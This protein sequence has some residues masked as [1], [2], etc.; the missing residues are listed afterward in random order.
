MQ[1]LIVEPMKPPYVTN[2]GNMSRKWSR[3][4]LLTIIGIIAMTLLEA[5]NT[6]SSLNLD[7]CALVVGLVFFFIVEAISETSRAKLGLRLKTVPADLEKPGVLFVLLLPVVSAIVSYFLGKLLLG[8]RIVEHVLARISPMLSFGKI[9]LLIG[10]LIIGALIEEIAFRGFFVGKGMKLFPCW[11]CVLISSAVFAA[12]H[13]Y[14]GDPA[15]VAFDLLFV[16]IDSLI[17]SAIYRKTGNCV[18]SA[19]AH[20]LANSVGLI[21]LFAC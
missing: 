19:I 21:L 9:P 12:G 18:V 1:A 2:K 8:S 10:Q 4:R 20:L 13:H 17:F 16:F 14:P 15:V 7:G 11:L 5:V 3:A 6:F